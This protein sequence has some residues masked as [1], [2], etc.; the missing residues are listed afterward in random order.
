MSGELALR[1]GERSSKI[2]TSRGV[3]MSRATPKRKPADGFAAVRAVGLTLPGIEAA[4][5]YDGSPVLKAGGCFVAGLATHRSAEPGTLVVRMDVDERE[6][7][8][9]DAPGTYYL[10]DYY[11]S[12]PLVLARLSQLDREA[13]RDLLSVSRRLALAKTSKRGRDIDEELSHG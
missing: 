5:R 9:A 1:G 11:R 3:L 7:L 8:I 10:T 6:W 12:Y 4:T 13:L 2:G